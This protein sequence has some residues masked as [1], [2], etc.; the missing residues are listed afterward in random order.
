MVYAVNSNGT[1]ARV[2]DASFKRLN[3]FKIHV[4]FLC[5]VLNLNVEH[6][7]LK[8]NSTLAPIIGA[9]IM[10]ASNGRFPVAYIDALFVCVS[11]VT[12]TGLATIELSAL[13]V[14]QQGI[15]VILELLGSQVSVQ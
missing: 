10:T 6:N 3:F 2:L 5:V 9:A 14:W 4:I 12:G 11:A 8:Y 15:I 7:E 13:T 1:V